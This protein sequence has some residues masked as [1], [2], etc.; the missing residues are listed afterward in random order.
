MYKFW[1]RLH[2]KGT[3]A[4]FE[5]YNFQRSPK[6]QYWNN[7]QKGRDIFNNAISGRED[8]QCILIVISRFFSMLL[9]ETF[10]SQ[11]GI[12]YLVRYFLLRDFLFWE[13][14]RILWDI[15]YPVRYF[16]FLWDISYFVG[17]FLFCE[18]YLILWGI[19]YSEW[20]FLFCEIFLFLWDIFLFGEIYLILWNISYSVISKLVIYFLFSASDVVDHGTAGEVSDHL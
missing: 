14:F 5:N 10:P 4:V 12:S 20:Y 2:L 11:R 9:S 16:F 15:S 8:G 1:K 19:S 7:L 13:L 3:V 18:I 6:Y 17:Y